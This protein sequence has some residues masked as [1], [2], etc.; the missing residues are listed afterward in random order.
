MTLTD[1][2]QF[3][4][5]KLGELVAKSGLHAETDIYLKSCLKAMSRGSCEVD[6]SNSLIVALIGSKSGSTSDPNEGL[7]MVDH[8]IF[9][10]Q[11]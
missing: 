2:H 7:V 8:S 10:S 4:V 1:S 11:D 6:A 9:Q 3:E 5:W